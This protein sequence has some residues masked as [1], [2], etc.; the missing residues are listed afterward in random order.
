MSSDLHYVVK[1]A[2][3]HHRFYL[4]WKDGGADPDRYAKSPRS[5]RILSA[6][7]KHELLVLADANGFAV[8]T[9]ATQV[10]DLDLVFRSLRNLRPS[11]PLSQRECELLLEC[12]NALE[13][14]ARTL[15]VGFFPARADRGDANAVCRKLFKGNNVPAVSPSATCRVQ[16]DSRELWILRT[17]LRNAAK[18]T[19]SA[20]E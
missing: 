2:Y 19:L 6:S 8:A 4:L 5:S 7:T 10:I 1:F 3:M 17:V 12:W 13:D 11:K 18:I 20:S 16:L 15:K 9:Q 14:L